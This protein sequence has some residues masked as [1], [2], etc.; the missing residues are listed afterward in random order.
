MSTKWPRD[1]QNE[2][3]AYS[4]NKLEFKYFLE[5]CE[6]IRYRVDVA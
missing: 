3:G 4:S 2:G 6:A 1:K 5:S